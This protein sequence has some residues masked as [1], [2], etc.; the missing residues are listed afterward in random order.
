[1]NPLF[2]SMGGTSWI[3]PGEAVPNQQCCSEEYRLS[4]KYV[5][6]SLL[7]A[8]L[9]RS[10]IAYV[11]NSLLEQPD[12]FFASSSHS[13][14]R[15][16]ANT[17]S[18]PSSSFILLTLGTLIPDPSLDLCIMRT[19]LYLLVMPFVSDPNMHGER[20]MFKSVFHTAGT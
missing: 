18:I 20:P 7:S 4:L 14:A 12:D 5:H 10:K 16:P 19:H 8:V 2:C 13:H 6:D 9:F 15:P 3:H 1:M 11:H 17:T